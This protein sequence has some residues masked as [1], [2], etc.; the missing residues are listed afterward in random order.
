MVYIFKVFNPTLYVFRFR[1]VIFN[2]RTMEIIRIV[3]IEML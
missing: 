2:A 3:E 1:N